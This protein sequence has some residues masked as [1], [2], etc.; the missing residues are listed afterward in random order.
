MI[1]EE[2]LE[3]AIDAYPDTSNIPERNVALMNDLG[4][5]KIQAL[6]RSCIDDAES[7]KANN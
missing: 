5:D 2:S 7:E 1:R 4:R 6:L 3:R